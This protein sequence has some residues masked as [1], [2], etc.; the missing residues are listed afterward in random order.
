MKTYL[1]IENGQ[2]VFS[3]RNHAPKNIIAIVPENLESE[4]FRWLHAVDALDE[5]GNPI[6]VIEV[7]ETT[8]TTILANEA[9]EATAKAAVEYKRLREGAYPPIG[10][11]LDA[12]YKKLHLNDS[13]D[14]DNIVTQI[15]AVKAAHPKPE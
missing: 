7:N 10:D 5:D 11:Q 4:D 15:E 2:E 12:I 9:A 1:H 8:K 3:R 14:W 6:K 13:T